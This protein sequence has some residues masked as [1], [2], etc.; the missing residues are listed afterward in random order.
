MRNNEVVQD[1]KWNKNILYFD[2]ILNEV[3]RG[4]L[5]T[6]KLIMRNIL[7]IEDNLGIRE[8]IEELLDLEGYNVTSAINGLLGIEKAK[9]VQPDFIICDIG[10]PI[11]NGYEVFETLS[12]YLQQNKIPFIFLTANA[13][14]RDIA[15][16]K[17]SEAAAYITKPFQADYLLKV[18]SDLLKTA[19]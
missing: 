11:K 2:Y 10:L 15:K 7:V 12:P 16:G 3:D 13:Q 17:T 1:D 19:N 4:A 5:I 6:K 9:A 14:E 8:N 18:I